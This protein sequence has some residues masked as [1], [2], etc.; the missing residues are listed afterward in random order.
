MINLSPAN[1]ILNADSYKASHFRQYPPETALVSSY[2]EARGGEYART[3]FFG[4]QMFLQEYISKPIT[5]ADIAEAKSIIEA[6]G[7]PFNEAGWQHILNNHNGYLPL[8]IQALPEG[9]VVPTQTALVQVIN[10][11]PHCAWLTSY[12]ETALLRAVWYPTT[13]ATLSWHCRQTIQ[14]A[15]QKTADNCDGLDFK[16]HDFGARGASSEESAAIGGVAHLVNFLGT[17][18]I[19]GL[20]AAR[21]YY[22][23][24][25]AGFSIPA[26]EHSTITA[27]G[28]ENEAA[29]YSNML[30]A[31]AG[32]GKLVAVVSDSYDLWHAIDNIWGGE[33]R[34]RVINSGGTL[35]VRPD[36][37]DPV[38]VVSET[39]E[40][41]MTV[42]GYTTNNKGFR[43]LPNYVRVIQGDGISRL[44][45]AAIL[46]EMEQRGL[47]A[48]NIA[49][50]MGGELLQKVNR[51]TL[52]FAMKTS[53]VK[54]ANQWRDVYKDPVT[55]TGKRSKKGRLAV[56]RNQTGELQTIRE[57]ELEN[58]QNLLT[59]VFRNGELLKK[60][61]FEEIRQRARQEIS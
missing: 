1:I 2:I 38:S 34:E 20:L 32:P 4:L 33:L 25:M 36:S 40:R 26:A 19:S 39:L 42:F 8:E 17:D 24:D 46:A 7:L 6:H 11:D 52:N 57:T 18:T 23:A 22:A 60:F 44:S 61:S 15:L 51:D 14:H 50:G 3:V 53:A 45:I 29:A 31:F 35:V 56:I 47:S 54:I 27:W 28:R 37:G 59:P 16:L 21:R 10:T 55:D 48:D 12:I 13:V 30:E 49:F 5:A 9:A 58:Q 41:L 43:V